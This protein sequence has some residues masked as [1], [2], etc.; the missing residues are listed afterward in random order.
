MHE[1]DHR[2]FQ[3]DEE[4][5]RFFFYWFYSFGDN[6]NLFL[7]HDNPPFPPPPLLGCWEATGRVWRYNDHWG[8]KGV[9][10]WNGEVQFLKKNNISLLLI[11]IRDYSTGVKSLKV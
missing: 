2:Y 5:Y 1:H 8:Q 9:T 10:I 11:K 4:I 7:N 3:T 6:G